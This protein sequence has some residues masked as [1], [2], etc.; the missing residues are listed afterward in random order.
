MFY[1]LYA[2]S[3]LHPAA[4][5]T[6]GRAEFVGNY[7][8]PGPGSQ[9]DVGTAID[10]L[11][12]GYDPYVDCA[13]A[14]N[15]PS[16]YLG[17]FHTTLRPDTSFPETSLVFQ[18][19]NLDMPISATPF[20]FPDIPTLR[21][22]TEALTEVLAKAGARVPV[23]DSI[24]QRAVNDVQ[25]GTGRKDLL[26]EDVVGGYPTYNTGTPYPD[27]DEDG[28]SDAWESAHGLNPHDPSD[29]PRLA[30]NG[31]TN[32]ENFLNELAGDTL[33]GSLP[34]PTN[35]RLIPVSQ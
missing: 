11:G 28:M 31:Y 19:G 23:L 20:G 32:L 21:T 34:R 35:L 30:S 27:T 10:L 29:G 7:Y 12:C 2:G 15:F 13:S 17:N 5:G 16:F 8:K 22:A 24:D 26:D 9:P 33:S 4:S 25:H 1:N 3:G 6:S 14:A 18:R